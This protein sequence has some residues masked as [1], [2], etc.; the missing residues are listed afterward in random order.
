MVPSD[1]PVDSVDVVPSVVSSVVYVV[2]LLT[3]ELNVEL[4]V[5]LPD[6]LNVE[7]PVVLPVDTVFVALTDELD[8]EPSRL[9][10]VLFC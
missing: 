9:P 7:L 10:V 5:V 6:E 8:V 4:P 2:E 3:D 1:V